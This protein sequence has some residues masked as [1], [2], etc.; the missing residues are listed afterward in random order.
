VVPSVFTSWVVAQLIKEK[1]RMELTILTK[2]YLRL[3]QYLRFISLPP[4]A[5]NSNIYRS[6]QAKKD[7][8]EQI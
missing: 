4:R 8:E 7:E 1:S 3:E 5:Q 6:P 2:R